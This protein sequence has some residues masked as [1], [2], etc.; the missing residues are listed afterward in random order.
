MSV[1]LFLAVLFVLVLVHE[2]GHFIAARKTGMRVDEFGIGFPPRLFAWRR[3]ETLY[4]FNAIPLGGF[5]KI[6]GE[7]REDAEADSDSARAFSKRPLWAQALVL[8][9]G[10]SA[11]I[12]LAYVLFAAALMIGTVSS[13]TEADAGPNAELVALAVMPESPAAKAGLEQGEQILSI[14]SF[15]DEPAALT[16]SGIAALVQKEGGARVRFIDNGEEVT[17]DIK[18][19]AGVVPEEPTRAA[20][21]VTTGLLE[22]NAVAPLPALKEAAVQT[23]DGLVTIT[24]GIASLLYDAVRFEADLKGVAGPVGIAGLVGDAAAFGI[25]TLFTFTAFISLNLA[26]INLLPFPALD[27]GRL[28]FVIV[29]AIKGTP[30]PARI[31][32]YAN[33]IG[34]IILM[35]L[36][37]AV[38][39]NDIARLV[40]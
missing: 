37:V 40:S 30:V 17:R 39:Y 9:A 16:P 33:A 38:T 11:N 34:F 27:G 1:L 19:E 35:M 22:Q 23:V 13:V 14:S 7:D 10:V 20:I 28:I 36:M 25:A 2:Y 31:S 8:V 15:D 29:E 21:G 26:V 18:A 24:T 12:L 4:T 32:Q 3:G 6:F 5:V